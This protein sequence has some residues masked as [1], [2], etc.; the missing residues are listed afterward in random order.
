MTPAFEHPTALVKRFRSPQHTVYI[1]DKS[2]CVD[3]MQRVNQEIEGRLDAAPRTDL[4]RPVGY[5]RAAA[6]APA[7]AMAAV[8]EPV[9]PEMCM[10]QS[11]RQRCG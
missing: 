5:E 10:A 8:P 7:G 2:D 9:A 11:L 6:L 4:Q 3:V 1:K